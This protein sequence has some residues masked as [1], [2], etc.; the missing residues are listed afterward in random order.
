[1]GGDKRGEGRR[2]S[3][4][5]RN[6]KKVTCIVFS[7]MWGGEGW[8]KRKK[9][10]AKRKAGRSDHTYK[11]EKKGGPQEGG[12][13]QAPKKMGS[14]AEER[15]GTEGKGRKGRGGKK[16]EKRGSREGKAR[17]TG[18]REILSVTRTRLCQ[19]PIKGEGGL[20]KGFKGG[21][22]ERSKDF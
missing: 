21:E 13:A 2:D 10:S 7:K 14:W 5:G 12:R 19:R 18:S 15:G 4:K 3:L 9:T 22:K 1:L 11:A 17:R 8:E 20:R 6:R 16:E